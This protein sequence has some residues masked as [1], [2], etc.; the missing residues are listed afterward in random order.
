MRLDSTLR[1]QPRQNEPP[2]RVHD[3]PPQQA[4][5]AGEE[6]QNEGQQDNSD[7][8]SLQ[9]YS[10]ASNTARRCIF[11]NCRNIATHLLPLY[12]KFFFLHTKN[13]YIPPLARIC[14]SHL[15][16][17]DWE[18]LITQR[19]MHQQFNG[20]H[21]LDMMNIYKWGLEQKNEL[22][23]ENINAIDDN[24]LHFW[25]GVTKEQFNSFLQLTPSLHNRND[26]PA[27]TLGI[28]LT[29]IRTGEPDERLATKF[30]MSRRTLERK[31]KIARECLTQDFVP[32][33][34]GLDH[35]TREE[36][37][38]RNLSIPSHIFGGDQNTVI[39]VVDGTYL[40]VQKSANF[41]FQRITYSL[42]KFRN[43]VKPFMIV[44]TDGYILDVLGPY[45]ATTSDATIMRSIMEDEESPWHWFLQTDDVFILDRGF[46]DS[47]SSIQEFG[48]NPQMPPSSSR[49]EQL[50]TEDAN[51]SRLI[52]M[53]RWVVETMNGRF[54]KD[55]KLFRHTYF[56]VSLPNMM[57]DFRIT[58]A[59]INA[60]RRP[61]ADSIYAQQ[62]I[63]IINGNI[64]RRNEVV[65]YVS[66][67]NLNRQRV[68][69][70]AIDAS[71]AAFD[72]PQLSYE[73]LILFTLG[74][75]HLRIARSYVHEHMRPNGLYIIELYRHHELVNN[76]SLIRGRIQSRHVR[77]KQYY[78]Y[79][80]VNPTRE[81]RESI[82]DYYC[83]CIHGRRTIGCCAH[84]AS[85]VYFL[86][87]ARH[88][89]QIDAPAMFLDN[90]IV[91]VDIDYVE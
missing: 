20:A 37:V 2:Q 50:T 6:E 5:D 41:L 54:K 44:C 36:V 21:V 48:Y 39:L 68:A 79:I 78:T 28:Y 81:G 3:E 29:K 63:D 56:N 84:I 11:H 57:T 24:E 82:E 27:T 59:I 38:A 33:F 26:K 1:N 17:N 85:M 55:Y 12:V 73:D 8:I 49:G 13:F 71:D 89:E 90:T 45:A 83:S 60:T 18:E 61:Y 67:H 43:L 75:Y 19:Q 16:R 23:F 77:S 30:K 87:W 40:N 86:S 91:P 51:K 72:F 62:F 52:T 74:S 76:R 70:T 42:H 15:Q 46:R 65:E 35:T 80:L 32:H 9:G 22:D 10:R 31:I 47:I 64:N 58:A 69:F 53:C 25:T 7:F 66:G 88:Q 34:L 4:E 14:Q